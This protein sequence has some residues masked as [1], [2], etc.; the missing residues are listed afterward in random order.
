MISVIDNVTGTPTSEQLAGFKQFA[1]VNSAATDAALTAMLR[2]AFVEVQKWEDRSLLATS[3]VVSVTEREEPL[4]PVTLY[5]DGITIASVQD[6]DGNA[7]GYQFIG[8]QVFLNAPARV[9][10]VSYSTTPTASALADLLPKVYR[11]ACALYDGED[12]QT[13]NRILQEQ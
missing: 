12:P 6:G 1:A 10:V 4:A 9:V 8:R 7:I 5:G 11:Y 13:L 3:Y 2:R